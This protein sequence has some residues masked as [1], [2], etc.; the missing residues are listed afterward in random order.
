MKADDKKLTIKNYCDG[1]VPDFGQQLIA[2]SLGVEVDEELDI[3]EG[4]IDNV[5]SAT[6]AHAAKDEGYYTYHTW[7]IWEHAYEQQG[8]DERK[9]WGEYEQYGR[10][11]VLSVV[12][13]ERLTYQ[14]GEVV[15][16]MSEETGELDEAYICAALAED[17]IEL[18]V[19]ELLKRNE[20]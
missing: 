15:C 19:M 7:E 11:L 9:T 4:F 18:V 17:I 13:D 6:G 5:I 1:W 8:G 20:S 3:D 12:A 10:G 14:D 2:L 16:T